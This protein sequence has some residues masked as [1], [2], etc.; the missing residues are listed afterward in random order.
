MRAAKGGKTSHGNVTILS[1]DQN[2]VSLSNNHNVDIQESAEADE[3]DPSILPC[4]TLAA[5]WLLRREFPQK[6]LSQMMPFMLKTQLYTIVED[7]TRVD[8][9]LDILR[10]TNKVRMF[11]IPSHPEDIALQLAEDFVASIQSYK[12]KASPSLKEYTPGLDWFCYHVLPQCTQN[13]I[14]HGELMHLMEQ[15]RVT[16]SQTR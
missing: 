12:N 3:I 4:D 16:S 10:K 8:K 6:L 14:T 15:G 9:E 5:L 2:I 11:Q 13:R 7:K 1:S